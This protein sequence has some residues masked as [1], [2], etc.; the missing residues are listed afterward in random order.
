MK[1]HIWVR[2]KQDMSPEEFLD[3]FIGS[4]AELV[5]EEYKRL[6]AYSV[7]V[8]TGTPPGQEAPYDAVA[9]LTWATR[10]DFR[11]DVKTGGERTTEDMAN[12][13]EAWGLVFVDERAVK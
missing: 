6:T 3:Y 12:F 9:E 2:R 5:K 1:V 4:H 10:D 13:T 8:A 7:D 11:A